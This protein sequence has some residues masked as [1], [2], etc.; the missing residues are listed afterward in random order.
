MFLTMRQCLCYSFY[1]T[2]K[3]IKVVYNNK[4][5]PVVKITEYEYTGDGLKM[6]KQTSYQD[7]PEGGKTYALTGVKG[8]KC[9]ANGNSWKDSEVK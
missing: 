4:P 2:K 8:S 9:I 1:M 5:D 6:T 7:K 3:P